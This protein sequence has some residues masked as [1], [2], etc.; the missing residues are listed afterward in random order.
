LSTD[1]KKGLNELPIKVRNVVKEKIKRGWT[2]EKPSDKLINFFK[3]S[4]VESA[5][6]DSID[7]YKLKPTKEFFNFITDNKTEDSIKRGFCRSIYYVKKEIDLE[8][9]V[10]ERVDDILDKCQNKFDGKYGQNYI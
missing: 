10:M 3:K 8:G 4:E 6:I 7:I 5:L 2:T 9:K 1:E